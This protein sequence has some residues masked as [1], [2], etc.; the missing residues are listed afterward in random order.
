MKNSKGVGFFRSLLLWILCSFS[1]VVAGQFVSQEDLSKYAAW[2]RYSYIQQLYL[3]NGYRYIWSTHLEQRNNF[4][5]ILPLANAFGLNTEDYGLAKLTA[6]TGSNQLITHADSVELDIWFSDA[7]LHFFSDLK[8]GNKPISLSFD[9]L[10]YEPDKSSIVAMVNNYFHQNKLGS[11]LIEIQPASLEFKSAISLL[12][13]Y[14]NQI[15]NSS[16]EDIFV[17]SKKADSTNAN[18]IQRLFQLGISAF[19]YKTL[20][21]KEISDLVLKAQQLFGLAE[22]SVVG[23]ET[24][25][26]L[27]IPIVKRIEE[28]KL[29]INNLRWL[30][31]LKQSTVLLLNIPAATLFVY[32]KEKIIFESRIIVGKTATP[33][34]T[35]SSTIEEVVLYPYWLVPKKIATKELLPKIRRNIGYLSSKNYQVLNSNGRILNPYTINWYGLGTSYFP[36]TIRQSTGCDNSLGII[37]FNFENPFSVYLHDTNNKDLFATPKRF[38]SHG[39]MRVEKP[40]ALAHLLL[41]ENKQAIDTI[42]G[43]GCLLQQQ[44][45]I[46]SNINQLPVVILYSTAWYGMDGTIRFYEDIYGKNK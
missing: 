30:N 25:K 1:T 18:L 39:C 40:E 33:T 44:P 2:S 31:Q 28:L 4:L 35:L 10:K 13:K 43:K 45:M 14:Q 32:D 20:Y 22:D 17:T 26:A 42:T 19:N 37:K 27:N 36:Y 16:F 3:Q 6:L 23:N 7:A 8:V 24:L 29:L 46:L 34:P 12:N 41:G 15:S 11:L 38:Y 9:G 21:K 5:K